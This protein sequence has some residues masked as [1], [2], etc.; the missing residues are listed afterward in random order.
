MLL[1]ALIAF[2]CAGCAPRGE[3]SIPRAESLQIA[4]GRFGSFV[5]LVIVGD[6]LCAVFSDLDTSSLAI[7]ELPLGP[8]L[9]TAA[10]RALLI[11]KIDATPPFA[12]DFGSHAIAATGSTLHIL[13]LDRES[14]EKRVLK[15]ASRA[16]GADAWSLDIVEPA[17]SPV[18][19]IPNSEGSLSLFWSTDAL[20][21]RSTSSSASPTVVRSDFSAGRPG[22][23]FEGG[24]MRGLTVFDDTTGS[25]CAV[26]LR[27]AGAEMEVV[28]GIESAVSACVSSDG[29]LAVTGYDA[30]RRRI[31][32]LEGTADQK[33]FS[34][35]AVT[36]SERTTGTL[37]MPR[38]ERYLFLYDEAERRGR[39]AFS[40]G[41]SVLAP[42]GARYVKHVLSRGQKPVQC[43][44][45]AI[46][47]EILYVLILQDALDLFRVDLSRFSRASRL[48]S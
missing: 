10:P 12:T 42:E 17:G 8:P 48:A 38:G 21:M 9:P 46:R 30:K 11:D 47:G 31:L 29:R 41:V 35:S 28:Q 20:L 16:S 5:S 43:F 15:L 40:Y 13:Y 36:L 2:S 23:P 37:I 6:R 27:G 3:P 39:D 34:R 19:L 44:A 25:L 22:V 24:S 1:F 33:S 45:A 26:F 4:Q 7:C 32:L 14:P 18:G